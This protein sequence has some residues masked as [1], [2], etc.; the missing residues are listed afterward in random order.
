MVQF[1]YQSCHS[2][3]SFDSW[4]RYSVGF[5]AHL[6]HTSWSHACH[7]QRQLLRYGSSQTPSLAPPKKLRLCFTDLV[8]LD[9]AFGLYNNKLQDVQLLL[10]LTG[11][12][13]GVSHVVTRGLKCRWCSPWLLD[14][15]YLF[16]FQSKKVFEAFRRRF[17]PFTSSRSSV[18]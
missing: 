12:I 3:P 6:H 13:V 16:A 7:I 1:G 2:W 8:L 4:T 18:N 15:L 9:L 14:V 11:S 17:I 10:G 5:D